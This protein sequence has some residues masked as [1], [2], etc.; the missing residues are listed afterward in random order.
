METLRQSLD[1]ILNACDALLKTSL[2]DQQ[3]GDVF[4]IR[5]ATQEISNR[6]DSAAAKLPTPPTYIVAEIRS[7]L[8]ALIGY[9][10]VLLNA[11]NA[12]Q[13]QHLMLILREARP[14]LSMIESAFGLDQDRTDPLA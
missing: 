11:A 5:T 4:A 12:E 9:T 2:T 8:T 10:E 6:I 3:R 1:S 14:L 13:K 7:P